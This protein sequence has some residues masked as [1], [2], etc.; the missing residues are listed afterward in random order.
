M[1]LQAV[2]VRV[3]LQVRLGSKW[4]AGRRGRAQAAI[5]AHLGFNQCRDGQ[6]LALVLVAHEAFLTSLCCLICVHRTSKLECGWR[7]TACR[8][9]HG[10]QAFGGELAEG[11]VRVRKFMLQDSW[12]QACVTER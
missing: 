5:A 1:L 2:R 7:F 3:Q 6:R 10:F 9:V 11:H 4:L 12:L 8:C